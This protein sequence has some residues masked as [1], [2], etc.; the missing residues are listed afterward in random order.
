MN[1]AERLQIELL[2]QMT[3]A[4]KLERVRQLTLA[5]QQLAFAELRQTDPDASDDELWLRLASRRLGPAMMK[6][7]YGWEPIDAE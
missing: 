4:E 5:V 1:S 6:K 2:R 3:P 7:V